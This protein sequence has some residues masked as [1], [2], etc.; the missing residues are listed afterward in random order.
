MRSFSQKGEKISV[1]LAG[2]G[3]F[4]T[5]ALDVGESFLVLDAAQDPSL[6]RLLRAGGLTARG[7]L[8]GVDVHFELGSADLCELRGLPALRFELPVRA[9]K[10]Q[11]RESFRVRA[12][13]AKPM[14]CSVDQGGGARVVA[15]VVDISL[16]GLCLRVPANGFF[17]AGGLHKDCLVEIPGFGALKFDMEVRHMQLC[18]DFRLGAAGALAGC[19]FVALPAAAEQSLQKFMARMERDRRALVG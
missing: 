18:E 13:I 4:V 14:E 2:K 1:A 6:N 8:D 11:R 3:E 19:A 9:H 12:P 17:K 5:V 10:L 7:R 15:T 16:G